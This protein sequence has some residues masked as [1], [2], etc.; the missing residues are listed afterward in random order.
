ML[1]LLWTVHYCGS[2]ISMNIFSIRR[3][4]MKTK[5][6]LLTSVIFIPIFLLLAS[7]ATKPAAETATPTYELTATPQSTSTP[8]ATPTPLPWGPPGSVE[9][10]NMLEAI[11]YD[12]DPAE[13]TNC[14]NRTHPCRSYVFQDGNLSNAVIFGNANLVLD[15]NFFITVSD[16]NE[17]KLLNDLLAYYP[18]SI[19]TYIHDTASDLSEFSM[20][21]SDMLGPYGANATEAKTIDE[22]KITIF[23]YIRESDGAMR[24]GIYINPTENASIRGEI[25][26]FQEGSTIYIVNFSQTSPY[27]YWVRNL[28]NYYFSILIPADTY[29]VVA[30]SSDGRVGGCVNLVTAIPGELNECPITD[31]SGDY[32]LKPMGVP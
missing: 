27:Y 13:N 29:Q 9:A 30:Y 25:S 31:W 24:F 15:Y 28:N 10:A 14:L 1:T 22:Y 21:H 32:P 16:S 4:L 18:E 12:R 19:G 2:R 5:R 8:T 26:N 6:T 20:L 3:V 17:G 23:V 7:C 11:G